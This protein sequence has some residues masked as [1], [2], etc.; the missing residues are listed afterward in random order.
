MTRPVRALLD[1]VALRQ[2]LDVVRRQAPGAR[3]MAVV[4]ANAYGHGLP[5]AAGVLANGA[6]AFGVASVEE[7][8]ILRQA[9]IAKPV[10]LLEGIYSP[11]EIPLIVQHRLS[12]VLHHEGQIAWLESATVT[13]P[14]DVWIKIDTGMHRLGL[15]A[16]AFRGVLERLRR[17]AGVATIRAMSHLACADEPA[18]AETRR[19]IDCFLKLTNGTGLERSLA[20]SAGIVAWPACHLEWV[21]PGI[22]LYGGVPVTAATDAVLKPVMTLAS[23]LIAVHSRRKGEAIGYGGDYVCP[24]DMP[25]GVAAIGYGD[26]YPRHAKTGTPVLVN[27]RR[28]VLIGRVSMDMITIDLRAQPD[29]RMGDPVVLWGAGL[30]IEEIATNAGTL[31]YELLCHVT[32]RVPRIVVPGQG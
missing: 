4:K 17:C 5:W 22:M 16:S 12:P 28:A 9:G 6:D 23:E 30:P 3:I 2:N 7:G 27:G 20:N 13:P 19:Q 10:C 32:G 8:I 29:A 25:V 11:D 24:Q 1:P 15:P 26:G 31:S 18:R 21:R 14:I